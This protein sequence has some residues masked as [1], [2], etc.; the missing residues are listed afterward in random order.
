MF[1]PFQDRNQHFFGTVSL[2][3]IVM[4]S[5]S[6]TYSFNLLWTKPLRKK[7]WA[8]IWIFAKVFFF[9]FFAE[10]GF[11]GLTWR[12]TSWELYLIFWSIYSILGTEK[13][14]IF[15]LLLLWTVV[16]WKA[17]NQTWQ[18][19]CCVC[20]ALVCHKCL[21]QSGI[22]TSLNGELWVTKVPVLNEETLSWM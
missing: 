18:E 10:I 21:G 7:F 6:K 19:F 2:S 1:E 11:F 4:K 17:G 12:V 8:K 5:I 20:L 14:I 9:D 22:Q 13:E 15:F 3:W 16:G